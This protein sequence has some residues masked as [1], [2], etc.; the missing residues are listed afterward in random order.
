[1]E[2]N[3]DIRVRGYREDDEMLKDDAVRNVT[4]ANTNKVRESNMLIFRS[5]DVNFNYD[6]QKYISPPVSKI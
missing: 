2:R 1:M 5:N 4:T 6:F 3:V